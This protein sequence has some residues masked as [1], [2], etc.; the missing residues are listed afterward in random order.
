MNRRG[1]LQALAGAASAM[2][3]DPERALWTPGK[4]LIS[5]P[6]PRVTPAPI[7]MRFL[8][9]FDLVGYRFIN[10][11]EAV[12]GF[13]QVRDQYIKR[14]DWEDYLER[15]PAIAQE[16]FTFA[17]EKL[18]GILEQLPED[19]KFTALELPVGVTS[20]SLITVSRS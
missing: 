14:I 20:A 19:A 4:K 7:T 10:R 16:R 9:E 11:L 5:I 1:F 17:K 8:R 3:F 12:Y 18:I 13:G 15:G 6:K 2:T